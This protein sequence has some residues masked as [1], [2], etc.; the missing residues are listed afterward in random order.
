MAAE[1]LTRAALDPLVVIGATPNGQSSGG[2]P[3]RGELMLVEACEYRRSFLHLRPQWAVVLGIEPDHFDCYDSLAQ[4]EA[5]FARFVQRVPA[6]GAVLANA[7]CQ[8]TLAAARNRNSRLV[9]FGLRRPAEWSVARLRHERGYYTFRIMHLKHHVTDVALRVPGLH[10]AQNALAAAALAGELGVPAAIIG[11]ALSE[12]RGVH[13]RLESL[14][15]WQGVTLL[16]DYAHQPTEVRAAL[17]A[18]RQMYPRRRVWCVFQPHQASRTWHLLDELAASLHNADKV[19][20][21]EIYRARESATNAPRVTAA[22]LA[23]PLLRSGADVL[24]EHD[25]QRIADCV[26][27]QLSAGDVLIT[28]G[29][30]DIRKVQN[31]VIDRLRTD[32]AAG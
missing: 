9:T 10:N 2:R 23:D 17:A 16:D 18:V 6:S 15:T 1:I 21:A 30:G 24:K 25:A 22:D 32:R 29:A 5:A 28:L 3:G 13:R 14:G 26:A 7:D 27:G 19:A 11:A 20:V 8:V 4:I 31:R 12:F